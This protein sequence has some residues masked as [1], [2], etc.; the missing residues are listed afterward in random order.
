M[1]PLLNRP[2][3]KTPVGSRKGFGR[4]CIKAKS[5]V[6]TKCGNTYI[7]ITGYDTEPSI[8]ERVGKVAQYKGKVHDLPH[9][10][11]EMVFLPDTALIADG[12]IFMDYIE[13]N[14]TLVIPP[15][16]FR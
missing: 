3:P 5:R 7:N 11:V 4:Y 2:P 13:C 15:W 9:T 8:G 10:E 12:T 14:S 16:N 6:L 1:L